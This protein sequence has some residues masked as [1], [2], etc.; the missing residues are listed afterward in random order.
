M[1]TTASRH[2]KCSGSIGG[3]QYSRRLPRAQSRAIRR[4]NVD[5]GRWMVSDEPVRWGI[6]STAHIARTA[7]LPALRAA[8]GGV[9]YALAG[10]DRGR[11]EAFAAENGVERAYE[12]YESLLEDDNIE[13]IYNPLPNSLHAEW[14]IAA[15]RAGKAVLCEKPMCIS[16][17]ETQHVLAVARETGML[18][19]EAF[20]FPFHRQMDKLR[21]LIQTRSIGEVREVQVTFHFQLERRPDIRLSPELGG[22]ALND[23][24]CYC[25]RLGRLALDADPTDGIA[26]ADWAEEGVDMGATG[27][28]SFSDSRHLVLSCAMDL[29]QDTFARIIGSAG[30]IRLT[31]PY[32]PG[33]D[34]TLE[35]RGGTSVER[36]SAEQSEP[37][38]TPALRYINRVLRGLEEPQHLAVDE[39]LGNAVGLELLHRS[40]R[41]NRREMA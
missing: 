34:D 32:H 26:I 31:G 10:R 7:F 12:G 3:W 8:G 19:W 20:V 40:A 25:V 38:F 28:L 33:R 6:L 30:E 41:S 35:I 5:Y 23:V 15:L 4:L 29:P 14:T 16:V 9:A 2:V 24:G 27:V 37:S 1:A 18:L 21:E 11:A 17:E 22:G 13:A 39:A 36:E